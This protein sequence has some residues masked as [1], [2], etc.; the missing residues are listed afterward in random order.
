MGLVTN[1]MFKRIDT[2][3][4]IEIKDEL[5]ERLQ[6]TLL[7]MLKDIAR[8]CEKY[9]FYYSLCGGTALGAVRHQGFI[10]WDDDIDVFMHRQDLDYFYSVF[11]KEL[12]DKYYLHSMERTPELGIPIIRMLKKGTIYVVDDTLDCQERGVFIDICLLENTPDNILL[13]TI[14]GFGSLYYG[15]CVSCSR[16]YRKR[17]IYRKQFEAANSDVKKTVEKKIKIGK[18]LSWRSLKK[19]TLKY[20]QW[21]S[22]FKNDNQTKDVVCPAGTKHYFGEI[23]PRSIY[24]KTKAIRFEDSEFQIIEDYDWALKRL[25]GDYMQI[26]PENNRESHFVLD[27]KL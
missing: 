11:D 9:G 2:A 21:N 13:R 23:F 22:L 1:R 27:I 18:F 4:Q 19:W 20:N 6:K 10:P 16:F 24:M 25:Y 12:G 8:I 17:D 5:L 26:P 3:N 15:L 14:H 7:E